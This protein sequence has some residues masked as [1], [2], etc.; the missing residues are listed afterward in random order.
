MFSS[1]GKFRAYFL[2]FEGG[3]PQTT[4]IYKRAFWRLAF[5]LFLIPCDP[6]YNL[7]IFVRNRQR[8]FY[9]IFSKCASKWYKFFINI[10]YAIWKLLKK[11]TT[12]CRLSP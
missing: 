8:V 4:L 9:L 6:N 7:N 5:C 3:I 1:T 10:R 2:F 12:T 11:K